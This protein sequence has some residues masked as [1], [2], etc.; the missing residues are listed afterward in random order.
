MQHLLSDLAASTASIDALKQLMTLLALGSVRV[1]AAFIVLPATSDQ[2]LQGMSRNGLCL[3]LGLYVAWGQPAEL[4]H[5]LGAAAVAALLVKELLVGLLLGFAASTVFWVAEGVGTLIDNQA[6]FN[7]VQQTN[8]LSGEQST[9][10]GNLLGQLA[11]GGFWLL[12][13]MTVLAGLLFESFAWWPLAQPLP[14]VSALLERFAAAQLS[15]TFETLVKVAAPVLLVLVLVDLGFGLIG[16]TAE[17]LEPNSLAQPVKGAVALVMLS[18]LV[19]LFFEQARPALA[20]HTLADELRRW[21][22]P[23]PR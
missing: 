6:G 18:L 15:L 12:G 2:V 23:V 22:P 20:L 21:L 9:P 14:Q 19:A 10:V 5:E 8:P 3:L 7:N 17:K 16:K 4:L 11:I 13:G 1:Y